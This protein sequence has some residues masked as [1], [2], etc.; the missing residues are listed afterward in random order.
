ME[1]TNLDVGSPVAGSTSSFFPP[2]AAADII[3]R[4]LGKKTRERGAGGARW[5]AK[6]VAGR[7]GGAGFFL[8]LAPRRIGPPV[9]AWG[10]N[11]V[12]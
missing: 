6:G 9:G 5:A 2:P 12:R 10:P 1:S 4:R 8:N 3:R 7:G 11:D